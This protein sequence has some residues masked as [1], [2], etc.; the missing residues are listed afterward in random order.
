MEVGSTINPVFFVYAAAENA[1]LTT[2][3]VDATIAG[4]NEGPGQ[5]FEVVSES[6]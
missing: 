5:D 3:D 1:L 2:G 6:A 4:L